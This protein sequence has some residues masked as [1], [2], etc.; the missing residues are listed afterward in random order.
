MIFLLGC[1]AFFVFKDFLLL[2]YMPPVIPKTVEV[3]CMYWTWE[4]I[5]WELLAVIMY[6]KKPEIE[7]KIEEH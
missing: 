6:H 1:A 2:I 7:A 4:V 3:I 5:G